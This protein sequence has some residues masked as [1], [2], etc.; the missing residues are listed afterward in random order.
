MAGQEK[1][2]IL[3]PMDAWGVC[4][5]SGS[6]H[7]GQAQTLLRA[8]LAVRASTGRSKVTRVSVMLR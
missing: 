5:C 8:L 2:C 4:C 7:Q 1:N 3:N 6:Y